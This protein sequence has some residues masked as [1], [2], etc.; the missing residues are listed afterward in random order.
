MTIRYINVSVGSALANGDV[1]IEHKGKGT[2]QGNS[3]SLAYDD[4]V[5]TK[6]NQLL[7]A[8]RNILVAVQSDKDL[9]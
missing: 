1:V 7:A 2:A 3:V 4:A 5:V 6:K 9:T 8:V